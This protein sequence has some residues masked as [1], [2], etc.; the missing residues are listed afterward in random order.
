MVLGDFVGGF[1]WFW[2][3]LGGFWWFRVLV[4]TPFAHA[5]SISRSRSMQL[6]SGPNLNPLQYRRRDK[7]VEIVPSVH[8][9]S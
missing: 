8:E 9:R 6:I 2:M 7:L 4:T 1:G 3:V 5:T